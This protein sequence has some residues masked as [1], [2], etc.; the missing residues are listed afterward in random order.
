MKASE[1]ASNNDEIG[2]IKDR[3]VSAET[4]AANVTEEKS[5]SDA[6]ATT[7]QL[8]LEETRQ[9]LF[10]KQEE[11]NK[12]EKDRDVMIDYIKEMQEEKI[13]LADRIT[14]EN[15]ARNKELDSTKQEATELAQ[16]NVILTEE[17]RATEKRKNQLEKVRLK[18][19]KL[20]M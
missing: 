8:E 10:M 3:L 1:L 15:N 4:A 14:S 12:F 20:K 9:V 19:Q 6:H 17:L 16:T 5:S 7:T 11:L 2:S 13:L 18:I